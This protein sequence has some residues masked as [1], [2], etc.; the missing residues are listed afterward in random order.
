[1]QT[2]HQFTEADF[3]PVTG[4]PNQTRQ[5]TPVKCLAGGVVDFSGPAWLRFTLGPAAVNIKSVF[6]APVEQP[7]PQRYQVNLAAGELARL[8]KR[9]NT[10]NT[11]KLDDS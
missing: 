9:A 1:M 5:P 8:Q 2:G 6:K 4:P 10:A 11:G 3:L 7:Q